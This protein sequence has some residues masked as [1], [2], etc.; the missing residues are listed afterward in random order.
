M[1]NAHKMF[2]GSSSIYIS[3]KTSERYLKFLGSI[4]MERH[5]LNV[6]C[7]FHLRPVSRQY[8]FT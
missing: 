7:K 8:L 4:E 2:R 1:L 3:L 5:F 6:L